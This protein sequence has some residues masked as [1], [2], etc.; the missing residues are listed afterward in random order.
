MRAIV[1]RKYG[2]H[3]V[4][5]VE[6]VNKPAPKDNEIL[7]KV[8]ATSIN[9]WDWDLI[10]GKPYVYRLLF[11]L[12]KPRHTI[13]GSDVAGVVVAVGKK[14]KR[15]KV[16]DEVF[17]DISDSGFG[18]FAE[19]ACARESALAIKPSTMSYEEAAALPQ[20]GVL[21]LQGLRSCGGIKAGYKVLINGAGGGVGTLAIQMA[22]L[23][24]AEVTAVDRAEKLDPLRSLGAD[25]LIDYDKEDYTKRGEQYDLV[26][27]VIARRSIL[28]YRSALKPKG[29][30]VVVGGAISTL[31][32]VGILGSWLVKP[33]QMR[34]LVHAPNYEDL[35]I[36]SEMFE[37][38]ELRPVIDKVYTLDKAS[39]AVKYFG[40]G[41]FLGKIV[42]VV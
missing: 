18:G 10:T 29:A 7:V 34:L 40:E 2:N 23:R 31:L 9:S 38:G 8:K 3:D 36:L 42:M 16:G 1:Y 20:A 37:Q 19:Y 28:D 17:G 33:K 41:K 12:F 25:H 14:V 6:E 5:K 13:I 4:L 11:G 26:L 15:L 21:A 35:G 39:E 22:K 27:D 24:G 32:S 30:L